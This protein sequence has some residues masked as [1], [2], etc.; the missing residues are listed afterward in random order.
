MTLCSTNLAVRIPSPLSTVVPIHVEDMTSTKFPILVQQKYRS[1]SRNP[2]GNSLSTT[3]RNLPPYRKMKKLHPNICPCRPTSSSNELHI[4]NPLFRNT[5]TQPPQHPPTN[6][7][8]SNRLSIASLSERTRQFIRLQIHRQ[9]PTRSPTNPPH[10]LAALLGPH[11]R[12]L[13]LP[14]GSMPRPQI[15]GYCV[16]GVPLP[17]R[18]WKCDPADYRDSL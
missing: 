4:A 10:N 17:T 13:Q 16:D 11:T 14:K 12:F 8:P 7:P 18:F 2:F 3:T 9:F 1:H 6:L 5:S 15:L